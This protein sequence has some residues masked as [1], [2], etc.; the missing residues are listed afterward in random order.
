MRPSGAVRAFENSPVY[1]PLISKEADFAE[2]EQRLVKVG[3]KVHAA[4]VYTLWGQMVDLLVAAA[5]RVAIYAIEPLEVDVIN[6]IAW[7]VAVDQVD[8]GRRRCL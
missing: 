4:A 3:P 2:V 5:R 8:A 1:S 7:R 6:G